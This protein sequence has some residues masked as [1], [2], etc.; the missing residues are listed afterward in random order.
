[1]MQSAMIFKDHGGVAPSSI[2]QTT[3]GPFVPRWGMIGPQSLHDGAPGHHKSF[4]LDNSGGANTLLAAPLQIPQKE[5]QEIAK[6]SLFPDHMDSGK[7]QKALQHS[8]NIVMLSSVNEFQGHSDPGLGQSMVCAN[9]PYGDQCYNLFGTYGPQ[10]M[11][12]RM[13]LPLNMTEDG[14]IYV[15]A[16]QYHGIIRR[17]QSRAKAEMANKLI[18][19][20]K[21]Y[22]HESRHLHAMRRVR[23]CGGRFVN[24]KNEISTNKEKD[25]EPLHA[26]KSSSSEVMQSDSGN[27]N[28]ASG[29]SSLSGS[30][31]TSMYIHGDVDRHYPIFKHLP[32]SVFLPTNGEQNSSIS[33]KWVTAVDSCCDLLKI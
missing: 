11:H 5:G 17:R 8:K 9:Y 12:G 32:A 16:K 23:G 26:A 14:P 30:E 33:V 2:A 15:N 10:M 19:V 1:M 20:R 29:G 13:L 18:K 25:G 21:P 4:S 7:G 27:M 3:H 24:T 6:F 28:S 31:V 22:L